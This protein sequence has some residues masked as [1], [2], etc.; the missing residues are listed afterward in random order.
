MLKY[1]VFFIVIGSFSPSFAQHGN[2]KRPLT[3]ADFVFLKKEAAECFGFN[4]N[5]QLSYNNKDLVSNKKRTGD[6][7]ATLENVE[8]VKKKLLKTPED[9]SIYTEIAGIYSRLKMPDSAAQYRRKSFEVI[10]RVIKQHPDSANA[11]FLLG[12]IYM[13]A[14]QMDSALAKYK[15]TLLKD[16]TNK[17]AL[18]ILPFIHILNNHYDSAY[19]FVIR[20]KEKHPEDNSIYEALPVYYIYKFYAQ[21]NA[22]NE[23]TVVGKDAL[24]PET[25]ISLKIL[26]DHYEANKTDFKRE[27]LYRV[28][29]QV[30]YST[31]VT[32]K[33]VND[34]TFNTKNIHFIIT[35]KDEKNLKGSEEFFEKC[36]H[37]KELE[38]KY[39]AN[40][41]LGNINL[42]LN[43]PKQ[44]IPY[45]KKAIKLKPVSKSTV[46]DNASEDYDNLIAAYFVLKDS[47]NYEKT[48][49]EKIKVKPTI[50]P[51]YL[52]YIMAAKVCIDRKKFTQAE[53]YFKGALALNDKNVDIYLGLALTYFLAD[54][55]K[56]ALTYIDQAFQ[57]DPKKWELY[58][59]YGIVSLCNNDPVNAFEAFKSGRKLHNRKW[60]KEELMEKYFDLF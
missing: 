24:E 38:N 56:D 21:L 44:A 49:L 41:M 59:L 54:N 58:I 33:T 15:S 42:L 45:L 34:S 6:K 3:A 57:I 35:P 22:L 52:D 10:S 18:M 39:I 47:V 53:T 28:T 16:P 51:N 60:I 9:V 5:M 23:M 4:A 11:I 19:A 31:L 48:I 29:Y 13:S 25:L 14:L 40:K 30:C 43:K 8:L 17:D 12:N 27:L 37:N 7:P 2:F 20:Q 55:R 50:D 46:G 1:V 36:M 26:R 32:Y